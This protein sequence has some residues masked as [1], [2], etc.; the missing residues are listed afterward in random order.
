MSLDPRT[1]VLVG[2]GQFIQK[3]ADL[4]EALEPVA[5]MVAAVEAAAADAG[6]TGLPATAGLIVAVKGAWRY[7]DPARLV[8]ERFGATNARTAMTTDGGNTPQTLVNAVA[9]RIA[10]GELD[11]AVLVGAE[12]IWSRRRMRAQGI[13][14]DVTTQSGVDPDEVLG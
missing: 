11:V 2:A 13:E 12:G 7:S 14:R 3:P 4:H 5:M 9:R 8:A 10:A 6:A 1:P